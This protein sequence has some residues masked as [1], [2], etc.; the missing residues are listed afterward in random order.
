M[1]KPP[2][3]SA[4]A[5][6]GTGPRPAQRMTLR[7]PRQAWLDGDTAPLNSSRGSSPVLI[8]LDGSSGAPLEESSSD[9]PGAQVGGRTFAP[10][11]CLRAH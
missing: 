9:A 3:Q 1:S 5:S 11:R 10:A 8:V 7:L 6:L 2:V 4:K